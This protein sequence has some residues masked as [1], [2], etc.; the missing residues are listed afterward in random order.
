MHNWMKTI[1][2][3]TNFEFQAVLKKKDKSQYHIGYFRDNPNEKP[4]FL[5]SNDSAKDCH[6][7]PMAENI[8]G[9]VQYVFFYS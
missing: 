8:F 3:K 6:I 5:A 7:T 4:V 1:T 2:D 9:A